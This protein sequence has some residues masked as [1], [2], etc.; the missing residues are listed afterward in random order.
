MLVSI[1]FILL[2]GCA[3]KTEPIKEHRL[4]VNLAKQIVTKGLDF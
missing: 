1:T 4:I 3:K 2:T